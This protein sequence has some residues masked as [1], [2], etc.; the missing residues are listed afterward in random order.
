MCAYLKYCINFEAFPKLIKKSSA[1][2]LN[3]V[4]KK[5]KA[6]FIIAPKNFREEELFEPKE[7]LEK[8]GVETVITSRK[9]GTIMGIGGETAKASIALEDI[10]VKNY[11]AIIFVGGPGASAYFDDAKAR[12]I[13][14]EAVEK[15]KIVCAICIAPSILANA[16]LLKGKKATAFSDQAENLHEKGASYICKDIIVDGKIIT[17]NG[18]AAAKQFGALGAPPRERSVRGNLVHVLG[19]CGHCQ[20]RHLWDHVVALP[21]RHRR[22]P[23]DPEAFGRLAP[24][25]RAQAGS[26]GAGPGSGRVRTRRVT[27][28]A[29]AFIYCR[30]PRAPKG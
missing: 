17:S 24:R 18:P 7:I 11:N 30:C 20:L 13:A 6:L 9:V 25:A 19:W 27:H 29:D 12:Q 15:G 1:L 8:A 28:F 5:K 26:D 10:D 4:I 14:K 21:A 3:M 22:H 23:S 2:K 16:G